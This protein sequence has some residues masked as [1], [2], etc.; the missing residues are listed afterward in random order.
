MSIVTKF[1]LLQYKNWKLQF[2]KKVVTVLEILIPFL[3]CMLM[4]AVRTLVQVTE[5]PDPTYFPSYSV[6]K[7]S[8]QLMDRR[9]PTGVP[10]IMGLAY[11]PQT[12]LTNTIMNK[13]TAKLLD[14]DDG[15]IHIL[16]KSQCMVII[17]IFSQLQLHVFH[18]ENCGL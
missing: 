13:V 18:S 3:F 16:R 7:I 6:D 15:P 9:Y 10:R 12:T 5:F 14:P 2:R 17:L 4:V 11:A 1:Y 8:A